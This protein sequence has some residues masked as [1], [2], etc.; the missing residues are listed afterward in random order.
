MPVSKSR[1]MMG[2]NIGTAIQP[3]LPR[4]MDLLP[5]DD[6]IRRLSRLCW[7]VN[8]PSTTGKLLQLGMQLGGSD[9]AKLKENMFLNQCPHNRYVRKYFYGMVAD[10]TLEAVVLCSQKRIS[11]RMKIT[12]MFPEM[13]PSMDSYRY[14][15]VNNCLLAQ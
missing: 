15:F 3:P 9:I 6:I 12:A 14:V 5:I 1:K 10:A 4:D 2:K 8:E 11:N 7:M 13:N